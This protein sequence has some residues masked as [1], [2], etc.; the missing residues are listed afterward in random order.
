MGNTNLKD[1]DGWS[2]QYQSGTSLYLNM[3]L[4]TTNG[5]IIDHAIGATGNGRTR[6]M[7]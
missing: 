6:R 4:A 5:I 7:A 3:L 2:K 1:T